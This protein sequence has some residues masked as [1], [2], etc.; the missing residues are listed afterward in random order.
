MDM[1]EAI[2]TM[3]QQAESLEAGKASLS[4]DYGNGWEVTIAVKRKSKK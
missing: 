3:I 2:E 1:K 4:F